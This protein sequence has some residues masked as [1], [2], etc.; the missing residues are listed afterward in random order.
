MTTD[1]HKPDTRYWKQITQKPNYKQN[2]LFIIISGV[3]VTSTFYLYG[4]LGKSK[5]TD[6]I[7]HSIFRSIFIKWIFEM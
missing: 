3:T 6:I 5:D 1:F 7:V 2:A 4:A